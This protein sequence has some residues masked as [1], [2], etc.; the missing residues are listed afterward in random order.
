MAS[1]NGWTSLS[2][3]A[4]DS[5]N[6]YSTAKAAGRGHWTRLYWTSY[7]NVIFHILM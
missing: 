4:L 1:R 2:E 7:K 6:R 3:E 5:E